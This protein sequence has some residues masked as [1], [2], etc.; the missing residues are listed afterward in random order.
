LINTAQTF[1]NSLTRNL[2]EMRHGKDRL[3]TQLDYGNGQLEL[4]KIELGRIEDNVNLKVGHHI[5]VYPR[6]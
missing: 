6:V 1:K 5:L 4:T 3:K 2:N